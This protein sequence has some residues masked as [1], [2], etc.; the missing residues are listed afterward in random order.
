MLALSENRQRAAQQKKLLVTE[1][2]PLGLNSTELFLVRLLIEGHSNAQ[3][4]LMHNV[5]RQT[6]NLHLTKIYHKAGLSD[7]PQAKWNHR[8]M[9]TAIYFRLSGHTW[10]IDA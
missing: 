2:N 5:T 9:L 4:A 6:I 8:V 7:R 3:L 10:R 1:S